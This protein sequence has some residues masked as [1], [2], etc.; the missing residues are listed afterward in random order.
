M[1]R[2]SSPRPCV[3]HAALI[4]VELAAPLAVLPATSD[5]VR[6]S[7]QAPMP[8]CAPH[9]PAMGVWARGTAPPGVVPTQAPSHPSVVTRRNLPLLCPLVCSQR[10]TVPGAG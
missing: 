4:L 8:T 1:A 10:L 2:V 7:G 3:P 5:P 6:T 9:S